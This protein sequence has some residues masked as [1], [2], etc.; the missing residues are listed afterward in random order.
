[1]SSILDYIDWR[2]DLTFRASPFNEVD[3]LILT[4]LSFV[5]WE[6]I[7]EGK[8]STAFSLTLRADDRTLTDADSD[9]VI[10]AVLKALETELGA[11]L[12]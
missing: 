11:V 8:K 6:G 7:A 3:N 5:N 12:R 2:G 10:S 4:Q 9:G 1:M